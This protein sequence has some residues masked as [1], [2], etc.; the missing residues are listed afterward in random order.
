[1]D[2]LEIADRLGFTSSATYQILVKGF[3]DESWAERLNGMTI[4]NKILDAGPPVTKLQ[5]QVRDQAELLGVLNSI[6]EMHLPLIS[7]G[8]TVDDEAEH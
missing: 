7:V 3:L 1:M 4:V 2:K 5:G 6:Y 8:L